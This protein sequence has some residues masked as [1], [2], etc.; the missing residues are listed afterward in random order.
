MVEPLV[1][2]AVCFF[3]SYHYINRYYAHRRMPR[4]ATQAAGRLRRLGEFRTDLSIVETL[5]LGGNHLTYFR[6]STM[7]SR[8]RAA[9]GQ[10]GW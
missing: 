1:E 8:I 10:S 5:R 9:C 3:A 4:D 2:P 7:F 6:N